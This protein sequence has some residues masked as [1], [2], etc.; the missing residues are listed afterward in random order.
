MTCYHFICHIPVCCLCYLLL[1]RSSMSVCLSG[2]V[3]SPVCG[4][5]FSSV[6]PQGS[7]QGVGMSETSDA[8]KPVQ[9][10]CRRINQFASTREMEALS[11][12]QAEVEDLQQQY[13]WCTQ[14]QWDWFFKG[15]STLECYQLCQLFRLFAEGKA[16]V[17]MADQNY[18]L[19]NIKQI[20]NI[21]RFRGF[22]G[23]EGLLERLQRLL[24]LSLPGFDN[25]KKLQ[26]LGLA[27]DRVEKGFA[28][29]ETLE[30][31][32]DSWPELAN[33]L[34][35]KDREKVVR[36]LDD[37]STTNMGLTVQCLKRICEV[38][39]SCSGRYAS[40]PADEAYY[41]WPAKRNMLRIIMTHGPKAKEL[42][43]REKD[44]IAWAM[45]N[46]VHR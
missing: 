45:N 6:M 33:L 15:A 21:C 17:V 37:C 25:G 39:A 12:C 11:Q 14:E 32:V 26:R 9:E 20:W 19:H 10:V 27:P 1:S 3:S 24:R 2:T 29:F 16:C 30:Q 38:A 8:T 34:S 43:E 44:I 31:A 36:Y 28:H 13:P 41:S 46:P 40:G 22:N 18:F 4:V 7:L 23:V 5:E 35:C 42:L